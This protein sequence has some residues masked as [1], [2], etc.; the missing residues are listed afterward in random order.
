MVMVIY[1]GDCDSNS[2]G[3]KIMVKVVMVI[4]GEMWCYGDSNVW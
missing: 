4:Y 2:E 1:G 3:K